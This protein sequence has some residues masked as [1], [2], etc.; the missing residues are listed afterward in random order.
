MKLFTPILG[1]IALITTVVPLNRAEALPMTFD[2]DVTSI[3]ALDTFGATAT[4]TSNGVNWELG[5][6]HFSSCCGAT[7]TGTYTGFG[8]GN[9]YQPLASSDNLHITQADFGITFDQNISGIMFYLRENGG[10]ARLDLGFAPTLWGGSLNISGTSIA[11][12]TSGGWVY[13]GGLN[14]NSLN[15]ISSVWD[16]TNLAFFVETS[17]VPAPATLALLGLGLVGLS[18]RLKREHNSK[19]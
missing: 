8:T 2:F 10:T 4:G 6:T 17:D 3:S 9:F 19:T 18:F 15:H 5:P 14:T 1:L 16:G 7:I 12:T 11:P 13:Y